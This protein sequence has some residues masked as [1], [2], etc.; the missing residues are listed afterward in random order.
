[1]ERGEAL[2][3]WI[4]DRHPQIIRVCD[5]IECI[6]SVNRVYDNKRQRSRRHYDGKALYLK[7]FEL[8]DLLL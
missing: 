8:Y 7:I 3:P 5:L 1:M 2:S 4:V 6:L